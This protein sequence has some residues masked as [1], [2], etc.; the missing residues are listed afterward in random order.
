M[1]YGKVADIAREQLAEVGYPVNSCILAARLVTIALGRLGV[2][3]EAMACTLD[4]FSPAYIE[5]MQLVKARGGD[6]PTAEEFAEYHARGAWRLSVINGPAPEGVEDN[7]RGG[8]NGHVVILAERRNVMLDPTLPQVNRSHK[9][10]EIEPPYAW[11][12]DWREV[13]QSGLV[14]ASSTGAHMIYRFEPK[15]R[16][17][18]LAQDWRADDF[19]RAHQQRDVAVITERIREEAMRAPSHR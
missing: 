11:E 16:D 17:F 13:S 12:I 9:G 7:R 4:V 18:V 10:I 1:D 19:R 14:M 8:Y 3:A 15:R 5:L 2:Q 6:T